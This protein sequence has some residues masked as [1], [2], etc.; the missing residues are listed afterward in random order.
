[1]AKFDPNRPYG[2]VC[3]DHHGARYE[4]DNR[5]FDSAGDEV[6]VV[7]Q[8]PEVS[9]DDE[10]PAIPQPVQKKPLPRRGGRK[11]KAVAQQEVPQ[12]GHGS[13]PGVGDVEPEPQAPEETA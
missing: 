13:E 7:D 8:E 10:A 9:P 3:G 4:Q 5:L 6:R 11:P 12:D 2:V 1:M